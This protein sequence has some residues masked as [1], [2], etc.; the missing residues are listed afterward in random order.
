MN[1]REQEAL[2]VE[3]LMYY[4]AMMGCYA[5]MPELDKQAL[6]EWERQRL[7]VDERRATS[8]WPGWER[9]IGKFPMADVEPEKKKRPISN[10]LRFRVY[11]RDGFACVICSSRAELTLDHIRPESKGGLGTFDNLQTLCR[12]CNCTKG[13][14]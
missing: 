4:G 6:H 12:S 5:A 1:K 14:H 2:Q 13:A 11:E 10:A 3:I 8:D 7:S 9:Y